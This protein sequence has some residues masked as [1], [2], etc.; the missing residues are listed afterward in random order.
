MG[1]GMIPRTWKIG[2]LYNKIPH[3]GW[4]TNNRNL[5]ISYSSG[6]WQVHSQGAS[7]FSIWRGPTFWFIDGNFS[8]CPY[9]VGGERQLSMVSL[10]AALIP[11]MTA[12]SSRSNH[13]PVPPHLLIPSHQ[14][15]GFNTRI[16]GGHKY[17]DHGRNPLC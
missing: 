6:S 3:I 11:L 4:L 10:I 15:L 9:I 12:L 5:C 13:L 17:S 2:R 16:L 14:G 7:Q 8:L 1:V